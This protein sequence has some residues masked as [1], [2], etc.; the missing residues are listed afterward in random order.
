MFVDAEYAWGS[1]KANAELFTFLALG[2]AVEEAGLTFADGFD[3]D[4][5]DTDEECFEAGVAVVDDDDEGLTYPD[6]LWRLLFA[7]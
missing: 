5:F 1:K 3:T 7:R 2:G 6:L 4:G